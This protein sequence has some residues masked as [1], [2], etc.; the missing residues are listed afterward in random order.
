[1]L[2]LI[3]FASWMLTRGRCRHCNARL[4]V[5]YPL[6]ELAAVIVAVWSAAATTGWRYLASCALGWALLAISIIEWRKSGKLYVPLVAGVLWLAWLYV[7]A[8]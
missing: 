4:S 1:M 3:P 2:D 7:P 8:H 5:F 6:I